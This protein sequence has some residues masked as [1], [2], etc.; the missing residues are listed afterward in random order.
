M[1]DKSAPP[2]EVIGQAEDYAQVNGEGPFTQGVV[3]TFRTAAGVQG[4][5][6]V[7]RADYSEDR[8]RELI[9]ARAS[10]ANAIAA[11]TG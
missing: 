11:M 8:V 6:F 1:A 2:W 10:V 9:H 4:S 3:V 7:P 5:V